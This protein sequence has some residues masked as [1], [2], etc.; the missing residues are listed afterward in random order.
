[1][2]SLIISEKTA[3]QNDS[4]CIMTVEDNWREVLKTN[5]LKIKEIKSVQPLIIQTKL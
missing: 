5:L 1:V 3:W 2:K 4:V